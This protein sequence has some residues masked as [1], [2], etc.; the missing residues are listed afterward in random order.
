[1]WVCQLDHSRRPDAH[2]SVGE[3]GVHVSIGGAVCSVRARNSLGTLSARQAVNPVNSRCA[4]NTV[5]A[6]DTW[7]SRSFPVSQPVPSL[8]TEARPV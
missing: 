3:R 6:V 1:M 7:C 4:V 5:G 2:L 8:P